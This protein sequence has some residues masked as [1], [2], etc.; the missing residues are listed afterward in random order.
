MLSNPNSGIVSPEDSTI[1][2]RKMFNDNQDLPNSGVIPEYHLTDDGTIVSK[3]SGVVN[4]RNTTKEWHDLPVPRKGLK[5]S[6]II[7]KLGS[8]TI[9]FYRQHRIEYDQLSPVSLIMRQT[10]N[11][12]LVETANKS[13]IIF[14]INMFS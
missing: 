1:S 4:C 10:P 14:N 13:L 12:T 11:L 3:G 6:D 2:N 9:K 5:V 7:G 8:I